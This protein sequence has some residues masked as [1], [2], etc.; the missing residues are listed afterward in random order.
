MTETVK[1]S[2]DL[3]YEAL[4]GP[5]RI[6]E[7]QPTIARNL[8]L[9]GVLA[10]A[11]GGSLW[12]WNLL[13]H[14]DLP[15]FNPALLR[16]WIFAGLVL[17]LIHVARDRSL[18]IRRSY[19]FA[20]FVFGLFGS[21]VLILTTV[22]AWSGSVLAGEIAAAVAGV[23]F[24]AALV[25][26]FVRDCVSAE[27]GQGPL[28]RWWRGLG[29]SSIVQKVSV[30]GL[31]TLAAV[32]VAGHA[33]RQ[34]DVMFYALGSLAF[35]L[36]LM[37]A[38]I[39]HETVG[40]W[41]DAGIF[42]AGAV[43]AALALFGLGTVATDWLHLGENVLPHGLVFGIVGLIFLWSFVALKGSETD[44]GHWTAV[45]MSAAGLL[46]VLLTVARI[47]V[48]ALEFPT[49]SLRVPS[50][51]VLCALGGLY[52]I[53]GAALF[54][55][56]R[57]LAM[58]RRELAAFFYSPVA[59]VVIAGIA[60]VAWGAFYLFMSRLVGTTDLDARPIPEPI[61]KWY[62]FAFFPVLALILAVPAVTM[63]LLSEE[64][65]TG[66]LEVLLTAP[67]DE[68]SI[69]LSKFLAA[70][71]FFMLTWLVWGIFPVIL[72]VMGRE[73]F[74][75]R[76]LLSFYLGMAFM[77]AGFLSMGLFFSS[78]TRNQIIAYILGV[79]GMVGLTALAFLLWQFM[80]SPATAADNK[81]RLLRELSYLHHM[82]EMIE[83][84]VHL[85]FLLVHI[86][87]TVFWIFVTVKVLEARKWS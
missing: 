4:E 25:V 64:K 44:L 13:E 66:T 59:Y 39:G 36:V 81:V 41:R 74:D 65:R 87:A 1:D 22:A 58:T 43:G 83:G 51:F 14:A 19:G 18:A 11:V 69:V 2:D 86:S 67:V 30:T 10:L 47:L 46:V 35:G 42:F 37:L 49:P 40:A 6:D 28:G 53:I 71:I 21:V 60:L 61:V 33:L 50:S 80:D 24:V 82:D 77:T 15:R 68:W 54:S 29:T 9:I 75:Y 23:F 34:A 85:D 32:C 52:A 27:A 16:I 3:K 70:W 57:L 55:D 79:A 76:P 5:S 45:G 12:F 84:K 26:P 7:G 63:R 31:V 38:F 62:L 56:N 72:R 17:T 48:P 73:E 8:G 78:L 20:G